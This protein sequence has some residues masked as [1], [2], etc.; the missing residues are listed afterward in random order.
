[1]RKKEEMNKETDKKKE[2]KNRLWHGMVWCGV[3]WYGVRSI[4]ACLL[5]FFFFRWLGRVYW[6]GLKC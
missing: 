1:M 2:T 4:S 5:A 6:T 3:M